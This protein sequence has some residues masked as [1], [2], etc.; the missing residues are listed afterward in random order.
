MNIN[1]EI[2][3]ILLEI[4]STENYT[5]KYD[6]DFYD[7]EDDDE[8]GDDRA[9][10]NLQNY[11]ITIDKLIQEQLIIGN[12]FDRRLFLTEKGQDIIN[13][14]GWINHLNSIK[15]NKEKDIEKNNYDFLTKKWIYKTRF[16]PYIFSFLALVISIYAAFFKDK[17]ENINTG[18]KLNSLETSIKKI[19]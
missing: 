2:E 9:H 12:K 11:N 10:I 15:E 7:D 6:D 1:N 4:N 19:N 3:K 5:K 18:K 13:K 17:K 8:I 16:L 14:G